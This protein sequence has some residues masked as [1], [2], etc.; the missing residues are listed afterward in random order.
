MRRKN[1]FQ[2][3]IW[4]VLLLVAVP[5]VFGQRVSIGFVGG[6]NLTHDFHTF[7]TDYLDPAFSGGL[8]SFF[9]YS[10]SHSF[11][12]GPTIEVPLPKNFSV[13]VDA[14]HRSLQLK[15]AYILPGGQKVNEQD[16]STGT[17]EFPLL[18]K[19]KVPLSK[20]QPFIEMGPSFRVRKNPG[21]A[22]PRSYG[23]TAGLGAEF[24]VGRFRIAPVIRYTRWATDPPYPTTS[25]TPD[26]I[27]FL[28]NIS[29]AST[30]RAWNVFGGEL[31]AGLVAGIAITNGLEPN[32]PFGVRV[33]ESQSYAVGL[34]AEFDLAHRFSAEVEA[35]YHPLRAHLV[36]FDG[37]TDRTA[38]SVVTW[39]FPV[40]A[41]Y[42]L[43]T[44]PKLQPFIEAGPSF[45]LTGNLNG[46]N[47]SHYGF[48]AGAGIETH[49]HL[50]RI[51]P[52]VRYIHWA[53]DLNPFNLR[54]IREQTRTNQVEL[55]VGFSF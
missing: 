20:V 28:T 25:T 35:L 33:S 51:A 22:D 48:T 12:A 24:G 37:A 34:M 23:V 1:L 3:A 30:L 21:S 10:D 8:T 17:W 18:L 39:E 7:R 27:E 32:P 26:Q 9:L 29:Y 6:T 42:K 2:P 47:P 36:E 13:E 52:V 15:R 45:R 46:Y 55:L 31:H 40:L 44:A 38:F 4:V 43:R 11:I 49:A 19:Y 54:N 50:L 16:N 14:F 5:G 53:A 41:K